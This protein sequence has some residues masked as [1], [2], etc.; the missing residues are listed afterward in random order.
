MRKLRQANGPDRLTEDSWMRCAY[1]LHPAAWGNEMI[2][3]P[4]V[5]WLA[6]LKPFDT[7]PGYAD[8]ITEV[9]YMCDDC[10][11]S[12]ALEGKFAKVDWQHCGLQEK[13]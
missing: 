4:Y 1:G 2:A 10:R 7:V 5:T 9:I 8:L 13:R 11:E 3:R 12:S 6:V